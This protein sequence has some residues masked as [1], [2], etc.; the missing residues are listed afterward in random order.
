M[1]IPD[2]FREA[3]SDG[4]RDGEVLAAKPGARWCAVETVAGVT[5]GDEVELRHGMLQSMVMRHSLKADAVGQTPW[6]GEPKT[7]ESTIR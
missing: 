7:M 2:L 3:A 1:F 5:L 4:V 6:L